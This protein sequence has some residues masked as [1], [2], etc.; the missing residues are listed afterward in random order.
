MKNPIAEPKFFD[1]KTF[2]LVQEEKGLVV[3]RDYYHPQQLKRFVEKYKLKPLTN[4]HDENDEDYPHFYQ[5]D[6]RIT[7]E[8]FR[9]ASHEL[10]PGKSYSALFFYLLIKGPGSLEPLLRYV[11]KENLIAGG[12]QGLTLLWEGMHD[13]LPQKTFITSYDYKESLPWIE[14]L[15]DYGVPSMKERPC[16]D[17]LDWYDE[18]YINLREDTPEELKTKRGKW[19]F[20]LFPHYALEK[21]FRQFSRGGAIDVRKEL[22][23]FFREE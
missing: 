22:L 19:K 17:L 7:D 1:Q 21:D 11:K 23:V 12:A 20:I 9:R 14:E 16:R 18:E 2:E 10:I 6:T 4:A 13:R 15:N 3:P 5:F 8:N